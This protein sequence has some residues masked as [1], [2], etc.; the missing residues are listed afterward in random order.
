MVIRWSLTDFGPIFKKSHPEDFGMRLLF[1]SRISVENYWLFGPVFSRL[2]NSKMPET[3]INKGF[4]KEAFGADSRTRTDDLR[5]TNALLYQLS[6]SSELLNFCVFA[7]MTCRLRNYTG[8]VKIAI[9]S[10]FQPFLL[11]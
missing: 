2:Q 10:G 6:H 3:R 11:S 5:I 8:M 1:L 7:A 4:R 9:Y